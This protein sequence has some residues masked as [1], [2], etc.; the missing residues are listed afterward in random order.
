VGVV[1]DGDRDGDHVNAHDERSRL[2][3]S[4]SV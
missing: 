4:Q 1:V 3:S 2:G